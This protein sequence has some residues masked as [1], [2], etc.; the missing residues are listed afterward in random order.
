MAACHT[1]KAGADSSATGASAPPKI[2]PLVLS[3]TLLYLEFSIMFICSGFIRSCFGAKK[4]GKKKKKKEKERKKGGKKRKKR[5]KREKA[6]EIVDQ[7]SIFVTQN[8]KKIFLQWFRKSA[9]K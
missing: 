5:K 1:I 9:M 7:G 4:K 8:S 3:T 6:A 2:G